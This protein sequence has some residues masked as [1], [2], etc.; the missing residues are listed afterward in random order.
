MDKLVLAMESTDPRINISENGLD[1]KFPTKL[2]KLDSQIIPSDLIRSDGFAEM[3]FCEIGRPIDYHNIKVESDLVRSTNGSI[4][5]HLPYLKPSSLM[6]SPIPLP[7]SSYLPQSQHISEYLQ[8]QAMPTLRQQL[9]YIQRQSSNLNEYN[10][11]ILNSHFNLEGLGPYNL[12]AYPIPKQND[13]QNPFS[14]VRST[15]Y[16]FKCI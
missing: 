13:A 6:F 5:G 9:V 3:R 4:S 8:S 2:R 16:Y 7:I 1:G 10:N 15:Q 12:S 14:N 11:S